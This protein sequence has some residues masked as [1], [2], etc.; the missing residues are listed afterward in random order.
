[1]YRTSNRIKILIG[2]TKV[3]EKNESCTK[4]PSLVQTPPESRPFLYFQIGKCN[5]QFN[6][7]HKTTEVKRRLTCKKHVFLNSYLQSTSY[8]ELTLF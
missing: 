1:M 4:K 2:L 7:D 5:L 8:E 6:D 3:D